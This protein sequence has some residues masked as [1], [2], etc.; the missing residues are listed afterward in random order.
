[1]VVQA[2]GGLM[3]LTGHAGQPPVRVGTS[4]GD[5]TAGLF[6]V[7]GILAALHDRANTGRGQ[8]V[9]VAMLDS[10]VAI[11]ENAIARHA[12][13]GEPP[14][15]LG[16]RHPSIS[17]FAAYR[18]ANGHLVIAAGNDDLFARLCDVLGRTDLTGDPRFTDNPSRVEHADEL[19]A[20]IEEALAGG[21]VSEWLERLEAAGVPAGPINTIADVVADPHLRSRNMIV[22][23]TLPDGSI[24]EMAGNPIKLSRHD[25]PPDR[26]PAPDLDRRGGD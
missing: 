14:G 1:M 25:D 24:V 12:A 3:S 16:S 18:A 6:A 22:A 10:Q 13:T 20:A 4:I 11:L 21:V 7:S 15:P 17:P 26:P 23:A 5:I 19:A 2:M 9:D 8:H